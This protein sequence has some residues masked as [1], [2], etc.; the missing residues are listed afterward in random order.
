MP[1]DVKAF[2]KYWMLVERMLGRHVAYE[3]AVVLFNQDRPASNYLI[4]D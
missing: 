3:E 1:E 4:E 2:N